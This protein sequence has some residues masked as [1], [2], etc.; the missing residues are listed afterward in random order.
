MNEYD[1][2][3]LVDSLEAE[4]SGGLGMQATNDPS[5]ADV[6]L[7]NTCA[8]R[9]K[10]QEKV[11]SELG[12]YRQLKKTN[13]ELVIGV[14]GC[15]ATQEG[16][17][18]QKRAPFVDLV[19][20][21]TNTHKVADMIHRVQRSRHQHEKLSLMDVTFNSVAKFDELPAPGTRGATAFLS[22]MEGCSKYCTFCV[23][24]YTRGEEM[25]RDVDDILT[26]ARQL[27]ER[28]V[29]EINLLGQNVN[30]YQKRWKG[31]SYRIGDIIAE[32]AAIDG[33]ERIRFTTS[34]PLDCDQTLLDAFRYVPELATHFNLPVQSGSDRILRAMKRN[35]TAAH[36][37]DIIAEFREARPDLPISTDLIVGFPGE[38]DEDFAATMNLVAD[39]GFDT[40][41]SFVYS[42]RPGT[43]AASMPNQV[44]PA[45]SKARLQELQKKLIDSAAQVSQQMLGKVARVLVTGTSQKSQQELQGRT[46]N[47]RV[48]N[49][50]ATSQDAIGT[51]VDVELTAALPNSF[52]GKLHE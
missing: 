3:R 42:K 48:V 38:E 5:S 45:V 27:A 32:V 21:P 35:Y 49:F 41:Y 19:F 13:P 34:H 24:P 26:E 10:A 44:D 46:E 25:S 11:Y 12:R 22:I 30:G 18:V 7:L 1:S 47:N 4:S 39:I 50:P 37:C 31:A 20:G 15:V 28:G 9:E 8:I 23:V 6:I 16:K 14:G 52:R 51:M 29:V 17:G 40:S 2:Q 33:I 43:P 36:Y